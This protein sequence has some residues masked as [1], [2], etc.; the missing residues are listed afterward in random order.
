MPLG[1]GHEDVA[2]QQAGAGPAVGVIGELH[3]KVE[4][5]TVFCIRSGKAIVHIGTDIFPSGIGTNHIAVIVLLKLNGNYLIDVICGNA[6]I[7]GDSQDAFVILITAGCS[8]L[9]DALPG[10][11]VD[12]LAERLLGAGAFGLK[13][14]SRRTDAAFCLLRIQRLGSAPCLFF[15]TVTNM[16]IVPGY[17]K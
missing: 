16:Y 15:C 6:A 14:C 1:S 8:D 5:W 13:T 2:A 4:G 7:G 9:P 3:H 11:S 12:L 10:L 17:T